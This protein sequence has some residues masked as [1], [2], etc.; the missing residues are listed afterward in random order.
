MDIFAP[1]IFP[2]CGA[3]NQDGV[4]RLVS[5]TVAEE[6]EIPYMVRISV[7]YKPPGYTEIFRVTCGGSI[8]NSRYILTA[9]HC[10]L[11]EEKRE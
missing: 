8:L 10:L 3:S 2:A 11:D 6:G 5:G 1:F 9:A 7:D 4:Y